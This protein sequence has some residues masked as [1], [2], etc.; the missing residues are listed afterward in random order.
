MRGISR[1]G[2]VVVLALLPSAGCIW[3]TGVQDSSTPANSS[4]AQSSGPVSTEDQ[5]RLAKVQA[6]RE[7]AAQDPD[8]GVI[9]RDYARAL[10]DALESGIAYRSPEQGWSA[11][12]AEAAA[13]V[14]ANEARTDDATAARGLRYAA[15][16]L[17]QVQQR[18]Q[19]AQLMARSFER[20]PSYEAGLRTIE[21]Y[22]VTG[23]AARTPP[24]CEQARPL[25]TTPQELSRLLYACHQASPSRG[26][27][28]E[29][30]GWASDEDLQLLSEEMSRL[31]AADQRRQAERQTRIATWQTEQR[32]RERQARM[33]AERRRRAQVQSSGTHGGSSP[34]SS[35][36]PVSFTLRNQCGASVTLFF[37]QKPKFGSGTYSSL[38]TN[39]STSK[40]MRPGEMIWIVDD[41]QNG[42]AAATVSQGTREIAIGPGCTSLIAR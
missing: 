41:S 8:S 4:V 22:A 16:A 11:L 39:T 13:H 26:S 20:K 17:E 7:R 14:Q 35:A 42:L 34:P 18:P 23:Q 30:L 2:S 38:G 32:E 25:A 19:A 6:I 40:S 29:R 24:V 28:K 36:G 21:L 12:A 33:E 31:E 27:A 9:A 5:R 15:T 1:L 37:G 10:A 3:L